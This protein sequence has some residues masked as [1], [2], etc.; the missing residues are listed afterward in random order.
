SVTAGALLGTSSKAVLI[1]ECRRYFIALEWLRIGSLIRSSP[2]DEGRNFV[3]LSHDGFGRG[4]NEWAD[5]NDSRPE[6]ALYAVTAA[7][8][9]AFNWPDAREPDPAL[10]PL[11]GA[12]DAPRLYV[13]LRWRS[14][15][16]MGLDTR[17]VQIRNVTFMNCDFR[18]ITFQHC[19]LQGVAF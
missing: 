19:T 7:F 16:V 6:T 13:N 1:E 15:R 8:G 18:G 5:A 2:S 17:N 4:L 14:C 11:Y 3:A 12:D 9:K 10:N